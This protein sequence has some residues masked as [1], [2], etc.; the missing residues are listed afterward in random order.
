MEHFVHPYPCLLLLHLQSGLVLGVLR[1]ESVQTLPHQLHL[2]GESTD[3]L[4]RFIAL[5]FDILARQYK[6]HTVWNRNMI[7]DTTKNNGRRHDG[8][9]CKPGL[10]LVSPVVQSRQEVGFPYPLWA[11]L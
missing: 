9:L 3:S 7:T 5:S 8:F 10:T 1:L 6:G 4:P 11:H 2:L